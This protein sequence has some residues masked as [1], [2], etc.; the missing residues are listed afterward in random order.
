MAAQRAQPICEGL[1]REQSDIRDSILQLS[2]AISEY[3]THL[4]SH[5]AVVRNLADVT[6]ML[7]DTVGRQTQ[8]T[9]LDGVDDKD[10]GQ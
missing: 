6:Q 7:E 9:E 8:L 3:A 4:Q 10:E 1:G 5:T 2:S